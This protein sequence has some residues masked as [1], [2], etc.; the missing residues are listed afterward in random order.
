[1]LVSAQFPFHFF[2]KKISY[3]VEE[4]KSNQTNSWLPPH[5]SLESKSA[6]SKLKK[7]KLRKWNEEWKY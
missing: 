4:I 2:H 3:R 7:K 6:Q 5:Q 1:M